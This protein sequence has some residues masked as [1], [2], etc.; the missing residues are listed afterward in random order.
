MLEA[1]AVSLYTAS[2]LLARIMLRQYIIMAS[3]E[4]G[5][6]T[7]MGISSKSLGFVSHVDTCYNCA[8]VETPHRPKGNSNIITTLLKF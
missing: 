3:G 7:R 2:L 8:K 1:I 5:I 6:G 4:T